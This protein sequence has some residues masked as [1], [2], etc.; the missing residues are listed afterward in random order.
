MRILIAATSLLLATPALAEPYGPVEPVPAATPTDTFEQRISP[1]EY[2]AYRWEA[3]YQV[4]NIIDTVQTIRAMDSGRA[5]E[6]NPIYGKHPT[7]GR[8]VATKVAC[9]MIHGAFVVHL[10][11]SG[12]PRTATRVAKI[13]AIIQGGVVAANL[14]FSF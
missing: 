9:A 7:R 10:V 8:I 11:K 6:S 14:R 1:A 5:V 3:A 2:R 13:S 4:L 12:R